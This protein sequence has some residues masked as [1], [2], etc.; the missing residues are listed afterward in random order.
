MSHNVWHHVISSM[1]KLCLSKCSHK[2]FPHH[3]VGDLM[4]FRIKKVLISC[5]TNNISIIFLLFIQIYLHSC[6]SS[7]FIYM[8]KYVDFH[9][10]KLRDLLSQRSAVW[11]ISCDEWDCFIFDQVRI[12]VH[13]VVTQY[14]LGDRYPKSTTRVSQEYPQRNITGYIIR[15]TL[16]YVYSRVHQTTSLR[17]KLFNFRPDSYCVARL[18][19]GRN[20]KKCG[21]RVV[22]ALQGHK[23]SR[24]RLLVF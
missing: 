3:L 19:N 11:I 20:Q 24:V 6:I 9:K 23:K 7:D 17:N 1:H 8:Q 12:A 14:T 22:I 16:L 21:S 2:C 18:L 15:L 5:N 4:S 10:N 13:E